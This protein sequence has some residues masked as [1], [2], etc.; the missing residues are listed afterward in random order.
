[1]RMQAL[2]LHKNTTDLKSI[3]CSH[4]V[5]VLTCS[6]ADS[7]HGVRSH[8]IR[9]IILKIKHWAITVTNIKWKH[10]QNRVILTQEQYFTEINKRNNVFTKERV[11]K[12]E[13]VF[14]R[15]S[16]FKSWSCYLL[17]CFPMTPLTE[18]R[19]RITARYLVL[20]KTE[21]MDSYCGFRQTITKT[22]VVS[23]ETSTFF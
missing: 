13:K 11:K 21:V 19:I 23:V 16:Q 20:R 15:A 2:L 4:S 12:P 10:P 17:K 5:A 8:N 9:A 18:K 6:K 22:N 7:E 1:M 3:H 14:L